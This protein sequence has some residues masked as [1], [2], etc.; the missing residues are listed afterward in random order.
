MRVARVVALPTGGTT[1]SAGRPRGWGYVFAA[2]VT[3]ATLVA[4]LNLGIAFGARPLMIAFMF[5]IIWS[6]YIGGAGPGLLATAVATFGVDFFLIPP[7]GSLRIKETHDLVQWLVFGAD[8]VLVSILCEALH[9]SRRESENRRL[10][11]AA[12][13]SALRESEQNLAVTLNSIGDALI[14][15]DADGQVVRLNPVAERMIG[16]PAGEARGRN[17]EDVFHIVDEATDQRVENPVAKVIRRGAVVSLARHIALVARDGSRRPIADSGA[18][19]QA[20]DGALRGVVLVFR[21]MTEDRAA[22]RALKHSEE[23]FRG[24]VEYSADAVLM[25]GEDNHILYG[26]PAATRTIGYG[27][28]DWLTLDFAG[29]V[30]PD[31]AVAFRKDVACQR[32]NPGVPTTG[33]LRIRHKAGTWR[34]LNVTSVNRTENPSFRATVLNLHDVTETALVRKALALSEEQLRQAQK[35]EAIGQLAGGVAHD[36]NNLLS[37]IISF[38]TLGLESLHVGD[39]LIDDLTQIRI[40]GERAADLTRQLLAFSRQQVLAPVVLDLNTVV[41]GID[42]MLRRLIGEDVELRSSLGADLA[43]VKVDPGQIEQVIVNLAVNARDAMPQGGVLIIETANA[44][45]D[46]DYAASHVGV[47]AGP[48][49]MLAVSDTGIGMDHDTQERIFEPFFTTKPVGKGTGLGLS[50]VIGIV[51]Q[52]GGNIWVYSELG[53]GTTFKVYFPRS[54]ES[55]SRGEAPPSDIASLRGSETILFVEDNPQLRS[56]GR[57]ILQK[58]GYQVIEAQGGEEALLFCERFSGAIDLLVTDVVMPKMNGRQLA[59]R[60]SAL[61]PGLLVLY[62]SGYTDNTIVHHGVLDEGINFLQKPLTPESLL[63]KIRSVLEQR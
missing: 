29:L 3:I 7:T 51:Q 36:F 24:L 17:I 40:A 63:R 18:P 38:A 61:R 30:H 48:H 42:R 37:V 32:A 21:D 10:R 5:P 13:E 15:T 55:A 28:E 9:R 57:V 25:I 39:P 59:E 8:G 46:G 31:D 45:L 4:R 11:Q 16:W 62:M 50:T 26:S 35:M 2:A 12:S 27:P 52:S 54:D 34:Q 56:L 20:A 44:V 14:A 1:G 58:N 43:R 53:K 33:T 22:E 60:L 41:S 23:R 6:A 19:I 49:V 47:N